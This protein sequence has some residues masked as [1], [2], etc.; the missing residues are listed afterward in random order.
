MLNVCVNP[1]VCVCLCVCPCP[2]IYTSIFSKR[3]DSFNS[4]FTH[5]D[6]KN[7]RES[8]KRR[9]RERARGS[10]RVRVSKRESIES[11]L[12]CVLSRKRS[13]RLPR[14]PLLLRCLPWPDFPLIIQL[15]WRK[16]RRSTPY[17]SF[18][19]S[20]LSALLFPLLPSL[21]SPLPYPMCFLGLHT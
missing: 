10:M 7:E 12:Y 3:L 16:N 4:P 8:C 21:H 2:V 19:C 1:C 13:C 20:T 18:C 15:Q 11:R 14:A 5:Q 17:T 6:N 9:L